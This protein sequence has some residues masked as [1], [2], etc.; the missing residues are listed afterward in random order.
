MSVN[1]AKLDRPGIFKAR[2]FSWNVSTKDDSQSVAVALGFLVLSQ[3]EG[4][5]W[6]SWERD[7]VEPHHVYGYFYVVKRDGSINSTAVKQLVESLGW[8]GDLRS[9]TGEPPDVV[10]QITVKEE[11]YNGKTQLKATWMNPGDYVP[12]PYGASE[13]DVA[14]LQSKFGPLLRAAAGGATKAKPA[15]KAPAKPVGIADE[16]AVPPPA[17]MSNDDR[18]KFDDEIPF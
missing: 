1:G 18:K 16:R 5:E 12:Q 3:L 7:D 14:K 4:E 10:V 9:V 8:N 17:A 6:V 11:T 2:P 15:A 13:G